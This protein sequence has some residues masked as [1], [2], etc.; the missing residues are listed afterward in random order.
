MPGAR[1]GLSSLRR[2]RS[3]WVAGV[4]VA[5]ML[6]LLLGWAAR[7]R[8]L[9]LADDSAAL[10]KPVPEDPPGTFKPTPTQW[11][12]IGVEPVGL[13]TFRAE[14]SADGKIAVNEDR[15][16][17][18]FSPYNGR[19]TKLYAQPGD[20]VQ[21]GAPLF[22]IAATD[23]VQAQGDLSSARATLLKAQTQARLAQVTASRQ[24]ALYAEKAGALKDL[25]QAEA[26]LA[27]TQGDLKAAEIAVAAQRDRLGLLGKTQAEIDRFEQTRSI[28]PEAVVHAPIAGTVMSRKVGLGQY[29]NGSSSD[30]VFLIGDLAT[31][32]LV[33][34]VRESDL[35]QVRLGQAVT[36]KALAFPD[37]EFSATIS[38][39]GASID[40]TTHRLPVRAT[41]ENPDGALRPEMFASFT[42]TIG[43]D[44]G[45]PAVPRGAV[46]YDGDTARVMIARDDGRIAVRPVRVGLSSRG[47]IEVLEGLAPGE[48]V[49]T[50]GAL[51]VDRAARGD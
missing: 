36:V 49:V 19:V 15:A 38:Y 11:E 12:Q 50:K 25:Q 29:L 14:R 42:I 26:D 16:T 44:R 32:W 41:I 9:A 23:V 33:A 1:S 40:P 17:P 51:F 20:V 10:S 3:A 45:A 34:N 43:K 13:K 46:L 35:G 24:R 4:A 7:D 18:V 39:V 37:H 31:V 2:R 48:K 8:V 6:A 5:A 22:A 28:D 21:K 30:P 47:Y 27:A